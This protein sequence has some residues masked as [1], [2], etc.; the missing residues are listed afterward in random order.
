MSATPLE[1]NPKEKISTQD[2]EKA[3]PSSSPYVL[4]RC[5]TN[6]KRTI[7]TELQKQR[8]ICI[9]LVAM[10]LTWFLKIAVTTAFL[11]RLG[12]LQLAGG[13]L[14]LTFAN[15]TGFSVLN[16][17][18]G[19]ME[20]I[21]GQA[22]GAKNYKLLHK[23]LLMT[24]FLLLLATL[25]I[26]FLWIHVDN[27]LIHFGQQRDISIVAKDYLLFLLPDLF[28]TSFLCP[29]RTYLNS[30]GITIPNMVTSA[31]A[32]ALHVPLN[33]FLSRSKG[34]QGVAMAVSLTDLFIVIFLVVYVFLTE[35]RNGERW[36]GGGWLDQRIH[37]WVRLVKLSGSCCLTTCLEWWCLEILVLLTGRL[38]DA[39]RSVSV[40]AVVLN[41]DYLL[42]SVMLS[43]ATCASTRVSNELGANQA[44]IAYESAYVSLGVGVF[45]GFVGGS[46]MVAARGIWGPIFTPNKG[47]VAGVKRIM[48][49]MAVVELVN[50][51][52]A[53]IAGIV[54][55]TAKPWLS[56]YANLG[57]F[58]LMTL[59][60]GVI[61]AFKAGMNL[62]GLLLGFL[63]GMISCLLLLLVFV[64]RIDWVKEADKAHKL[65]AVIEEEIS[66]ADWS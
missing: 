24:T 8:G 42:Y 30:Q 14:G 60:L 52:V 23:T 5:P 63:V 37:D 41:F 19:A 9:P 18:C 46:V 51:P 12:E 44:Q 15:V 56:M 13:V 11:G 32:L 53:V 36:K 2:Q 31:L 27:I 16:G 40:L 48:P 59:P 1:E 29:L 43:L 61:L 20:P 54:R 22:F 58:Y 50:F 35:K 10:N 66:T 45:S 33:I 65:A 21:C 6:L 64:A 3:T 62:S 26:S 17:L 4:L 49:L 39:K 25:P 55:G 38:P 47:V 7:L 34:L 28:V 57:G